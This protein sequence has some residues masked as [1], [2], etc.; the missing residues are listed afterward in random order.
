VTAKRSARV[1]VARETDLSRRKHIRP[2]RDTLLVVT[3]GQ[4]TERQYFEGLRH[5]PSL[6]V[7]LRVTVKSE[8]PQALVAQAAALRAASDY[9]HVWVVCDVDEYD[10][11]QAI[12]DA[13]KSGVGLALSKPCFEVWGQLNFAD[14]RDGISDAVAR[15]KSRGGPPETNPSTAVWRVVECAWGVEPVGIGPY[16]RRGPVSGRVPD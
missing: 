12:S 3:N 4:C 6:A 15:A 16:H 7:V 8:A 2:S 1:R 13:L 5:D 10:V 9:D 14:F 11:S